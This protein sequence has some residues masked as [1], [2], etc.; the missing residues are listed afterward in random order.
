MKTLIQF[1]AIRRVSASSVILFSFACLALLP[2]TQ[3]VVPTPD[4]GYPG[5]NTAEGQSALFSLTT[6]QWN[7][8]IGFEA[9]KNDGTGGENT[10][11]GARALF[12]NSSG[13]RNTGNGAFALFTNITGSDNSAFGWGALAQNTTDVHGVAGNSNTALGSRALENSTTGSQNTAVGV[14]ALS[15][16]DNGS[17]NTAVGYQAL[18]LTAMAGSI[19]ASGNTAIGYQA[20]QNNA[21][22]ANVGVGNTA[23]GSNALQNC[24]GGLYNT[25]VGN[26]AGLALQGGSRN[27]YVGNRGVTSENSTIRLGDSQDQT[28]TF[29][30]GIRNV[31]TGNGDAVPVLIDSSGQLGTMN[32]S[33]RFKKD[34]E[35]MASASETILSLKPVTFHYNNDKKDLPQFGLIA[36][37]VAE[38]NPDLV[39]RDENGQIYTVRYDAVNAMLLNEF[40][41]EHKKVE[42]QQ[43]MTA[44]LKSTVAQQ[45]KDFDST[46]AQQQKQ[47][48]ALVANL[49]EQASEVQKV[50]AQVGLSVPSPQKVASDR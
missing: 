32:S 45:R 28:R 40:L 37:Q 25:A 38:V 13:V 27:I 20:L 31:T 47:I 39:V 18:Q 9:L 33:R 21:D 3:A 12:Y 29:I 2:N 5:F 6:G 24:Q 35:P 30:A 49:K 4:G 44:E 8:A 50:R 34:V 11:T 7:T 26:F 14:D 43:A 17:G 46:I 16:N 23:V 41:K 10:A 1:T 22:G 15:F 19:G 36:E 42:E 48:E